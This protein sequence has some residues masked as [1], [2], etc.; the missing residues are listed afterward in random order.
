MPRENLKDKIA[1]AKKIVRA[2]KASYP[3]AECSLNFRNIHQLMVA[4]ILSAQCTDE[5]VNIVT[6]DLFKKYR[7]V[8]D[9]A[10]ADIEQLEKDIHSTGFYKNKARSIKKS[11]QQLLEHYDGN[12][13]KTLDELVKLAGVGRKTGSVVLGVGYGLA[14]GIV[15]DTHVIRI[16]N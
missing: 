4:T 14:E 8:K 16:S 6:K 13:P 9:F 12:I 11:A 3:D 2:L 5:R 10:G 15:V 1:R 7:S